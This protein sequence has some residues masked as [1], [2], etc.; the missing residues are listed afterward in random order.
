MADVQVNTLGPPG[1]GGPLPRQT[2]DSD[3]LQSLVTHGFWWFS[4]LLRLP[5]LRSLSPGLRH[6]FLAL[7]VGGLVYAMGLAI[8]MC[9]GFASIYLSPPSSWPVL[10]GIFG[11]SYFTYV[12]LTLPSG[13]VQE[14][15]SLGPLLS[16][17]PE[18]YRGL[19]VRYA[20][21]FRDNRRNAAWAFVLV[22]FFLAAGNCLWLH[23]NLDELISR[24]P[25]LGFVKFM[26]DPR[27]YE[28]PIYPKLLI[29]DIMGLVIVS[30]VAVSL[31]AVLLHCLLIREI[32]SSDLASAFCLRPAVVRFQRL[33]VFSFQLSLHYSVGVWLFVLVAVNAFTLVSLLI[34]SILAL[35]AVALTLIPY[36]FLSRRIVFT[37]TRL[38]D[39]LLEAYLAQLNRREQP[40][41]SPTYRFVIKNIAEMEDYFGSAVN[42]VRSISTWQHAFG[43]SLI[44]PLVTALVAAAK[45]FDVGAMLKA[46]LP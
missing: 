3:M 21:H 7:A 13:Y 25:T 9:F 10:L 29:L 38:T 36:W 45:Y 16:T 28:P 5:M 20:H 39:Q 46:L 1:T 24:M 6:P 27:W 41:G 18:E 2:A 22:A 32:A 34:I 40:G 37:R 35:G 33:T 44:N 12:A 19:L 31:R 23:P 17:T 11:I 14:L 42:K 4:F 26:P 43:L 8:A 30:D 15:R